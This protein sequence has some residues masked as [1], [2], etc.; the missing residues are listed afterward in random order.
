METIEFKKEKIAVM[1]KISNEII[2]DLCIKTGM[3]GDDIIY[4]QLTSRLTG[5]I[6]SNMAEE[7]QLVYYCERPRF[8]DWLLRRTKRV[9][10][11]LKVKDLLLNPPKNV[12]TIRV[13]E[14]EQ[15]K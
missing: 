9:V 3:D 5:F 11:N 15:I 2:Q 8:L 13:Y 14:T 7:R 4:D 10:F 1:Q 12:N 6:Y